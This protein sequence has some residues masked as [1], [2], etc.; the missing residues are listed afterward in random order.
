MAANAFIRF[1]SY[2]HVYTHAIEYGRVFFNQGAQ[3]LRKRIADRM[4]EL[5]LSQTELGRLSGVPQ[6]TIHRIMSGESQ[7]PRQQNIEKIAKALS[8]TATWLWTGRQDSAHAPR[9]AIRIDSASPAVATKR[10]PSKPA[11]VRTKLEI[12][13]VDDV[14]T[15]T[16]TSLEQ[17]KQLA[18]AIQSFIHQYVFEIYDD[19]PELIETLSTYRLSE[20]K[21]LFVGP[22]K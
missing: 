21:L 6:P 14:G 13:V 4:T 8:V 9:E 5:G 17:E 10:P 15:K 20:L 12:K 16:F 22:P 1:E 7:S 2:A 11:K 19:H 18:Q 3:M